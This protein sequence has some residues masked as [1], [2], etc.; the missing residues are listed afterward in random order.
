M[1]VVI[2][3]PPAPEPGWYADDPVDSPAAQ[4][5]AQTPAAASDAATSDAGSRSDEPAAAAQAAAASAS[6]AP[7]AG[8]AATGLAAADGPVVT[9]SFV[10]D[11]PSFTAP[12]A[13]DGAAA[14]AQPAQSAQ[15]SSS[16]ADDDE[17][18]DSTVLSSSFTIKQAHKTYVLHNEATGQTILIDRSVLLGRRPSDK[19]PEGAK[20]VRIED[21]TRTT[22]RNHAA[23]S[24]DQNGQLWIEDYGSLNG[25]FI[26]RD[27]EEHQ[28]V[29]G[30]PSELDAPATLRIGDQFFTLEEQDAR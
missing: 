28:V 23:I 11:E 15:P 19:I 14:S 10:T 12:A 17:D 13:Q 4:A 1:S 6:S 26:I 27:G 18:W 24:I 22:S 20:A 8:L 25:T 7:S 5:A 16:H 21:P 30:T 9:G 3:F 29:K 2:P